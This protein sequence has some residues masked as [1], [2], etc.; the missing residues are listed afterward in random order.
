MTAHVQRAD[1]FVEPRKCTACSVQFHPASRAVEGSPEQEAA[2]YSGPEDTAPGMENMS[3]EGYISTIGVEF[4]IRRSEHEANSIKLQVW[5]TACQ[6][7]FQTIT[8]S[9]CRGADGTIIVYDVTDKEP[10]NSVKNRV[11]VRSTSIQ[12]YVS[13]S[14]SSETS[15]T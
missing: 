9:Y 15:V 8:S 7:R 5:D 2:R 10:F 3:T 13:T 6:E 4:K 12:Q 14:F 11:W 1:G